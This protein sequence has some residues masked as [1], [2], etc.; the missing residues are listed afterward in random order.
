MSN[1][2]RLQI[3]I[4]GSWP[5]SPGK[6]GYSECNDMEDARRLEESN[7]MHSGEPDVA[8]LREL[9]TFV[10]DLEVKFEVQG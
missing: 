10:E 1:E 9:L 3:T 7:V 2:S 8:I 6:G 5:V 4:T